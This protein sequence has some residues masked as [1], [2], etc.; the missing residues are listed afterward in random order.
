MD[1]RNESS[2][3]QA[4]SIPFGVGRTG[5]SIVRDDLLGSVHM[6]LHDITHLHL[7]RSSSYPEGWQKECPLA[8]CLRFHN[9][10]GLVVLLHDLTH[11]LQMF[12]DQDRGGVGEVTKLMDGLREQVAEAKDKLTSSTGAEEVTQ[13]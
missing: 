10:Q 4:I 3:D 8:V 9:R 13:D 12:E 5:I 7:E 2:E 11:A 6:H 1:K